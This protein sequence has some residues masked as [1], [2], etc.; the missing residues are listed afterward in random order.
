MW[1]LMVRMRLN[2]KPVDPD[3]DGD[4]WDS[5]SAQVVEDIRRIIVRGNADPGSVE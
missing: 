5:V 3:S 4:L 1:D 2:R